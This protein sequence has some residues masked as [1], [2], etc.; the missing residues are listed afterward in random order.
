V[1]MRR[2]TGATEQDTQTERLVLDAA[3]GIELRPDDIARNS[4]MNLMRFESDVQEIEHMTDSQGV[5][6]WASVCRE[7]RDDEF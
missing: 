6:G 4:W 5:A 3:V 2:I 7:E 1:L